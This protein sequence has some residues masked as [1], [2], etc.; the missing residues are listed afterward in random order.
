MYDSNTYIFFRYQLFIRRAVSENYK[1]RKKTLSG[2]EPGTS[3][4]RDQ[5]PLPLSYGISLHWLGRNRFN[6]KTV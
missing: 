3:G 6:N 5:Y 1:G 2:I 4:V